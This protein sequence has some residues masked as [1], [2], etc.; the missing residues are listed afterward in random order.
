MS[1][2]YAVSITRDG[3]WWM[4]AVPELD[5]LTQARRIDNVPTMAK[6]LIAL[7]TGVPLADVE[8]D[9]RI[10]LQPGGEDVATR[11]AQIKEQRAKLSEEEARV[12]A[13]TE[14]FAKELASAHVPV[15]DIGALLGVTFQREPTGQQLGHDRHRTNQEDSYVTGGGGE[16]CGSGGA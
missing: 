14:A 9:Q 10:E 16:E 6:E 2:T 12:K 15:R 11:V 3:K 7:E 4:I 13:S 5:V 1:K 8:I